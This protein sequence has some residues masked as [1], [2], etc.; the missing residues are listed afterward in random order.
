MREADV[1]WA[2]PF[3]PVRL[4]LQKKGHSAEEIKD[5][6]NRHFVHLQPPSDIPQKDPKIHVVIDLN[7]DQF[8]NVFVDENLP[9]EIYS[10]RYLDNKMSVMHISSLYYGHLTFR[11][12]RFFIFD[13]LKL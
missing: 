11:P 6:L 2:D 3:E 1:D 9:H 7:K 5:P 12:G 8:S 13:M 4:Y 10:I